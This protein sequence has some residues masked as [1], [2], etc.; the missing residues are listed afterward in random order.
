MSDH[1]PS[2]VLALLSSLPDETLASL[3]QV[4]ASMLAERTGDTATD[5]LLDALNRRSEY[6][7][8]PA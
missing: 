8:D 4:A 7:K 6:V 1:A 5:V 3:I 2:A